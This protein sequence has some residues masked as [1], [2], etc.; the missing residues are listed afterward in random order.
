MERLAKVIEPEHGV[1]TNIGE[2]HQQ[3]FH[4]LEQ[5]LKEKLRLFHNSQF[6]YYC[7][8]HELIESAIKSDSLLNSK[9]HITWSTKSRN[10]GLFVEILNR[11]ANNVR[12][13]LNH[14]HVTC[15]LNLPYGDKASLENAL[16][17]INFLI[18]NDF[19]G[20]EIES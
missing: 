8:D 12:I 13:K 15:I 4:S 6:I 17:V 20:H 1:I 16:H 7:L 10:A 19:S 14:K 9:E 3:N 5:K 18:E 2:A 11:S